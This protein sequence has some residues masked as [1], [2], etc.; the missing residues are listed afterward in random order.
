MMIFY[1]KLQDKEWLRNQIQQKS[2]RQIAE[3]IGC[4][5][6]NVT[7]T[8]YRL[9]GMKIPRKKGTFNPSCKFPQLQDKE[10]LLKELAEKPTRQIAEEIGSSSGAIMSAVRKFG[11]DIPQRA[12]RRTL[13]DHSEVAKQAYQKKWPNGRR[14]EE[15]SNWQGGIKRSVGGGGRYI[16]LYMP[17]HPNATKDGYVMEHRLVMEDILGRFLEPT[18]IVHHINGDTRDNHPENLELVATRK[19]HARIH[20]DAVKALDKMTK[21]MENMKRRLDEFESAEAARS[22]KDSGSVE[23]QGQS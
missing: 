2:A 15:A 12:K 9:L 19:A 7:T 8:V 21:M 18:E 17:E 20:N 22:S 6:S 11:I 4:S 10:W 3:E 5:I 13:V 23:I 1:P 14:G 16:A